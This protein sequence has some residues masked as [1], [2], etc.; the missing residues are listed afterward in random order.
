MYATVTQYSDLVA[1][2]SWTATYFHTCC[3]RLMLFRWLKRFTALKPR[4]FH[5]A[6]GNASLF[7]K[8]IF[9]G[10]LLY[11][12]FTFTVTCLATDFSWYIIKEQEQLTIYDSYWE[13]SCEVPLKHYS[14]PNPFSP[15]GG[16]ICASSHCS[17]SP[18]NYFFIKILFLCLY[19]PLPPTLAGN[20]VSMAIISIL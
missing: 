6:N 15:N 5:T 19:P 11:C 4:I 20:I 10:S 18:L 7:V 17:R 9:G 8:N 12:M 2:L 16:F 1:W 14:S 3:Q 13:N